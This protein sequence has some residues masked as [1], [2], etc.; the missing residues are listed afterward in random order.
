MT[1]SITVLC[2]ETIFSNEINKMP[3]LVDLRTFDLPDHLFTDKDTHTD[4]RIAFF[5]SG[6]FKIEI[7]DLS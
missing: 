1:T 4:N 3:E 2:I 5:H 7:S 6:I